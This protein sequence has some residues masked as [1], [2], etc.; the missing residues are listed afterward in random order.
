MDLWL[1]CES[2]GD[3]DLYYVDEDFPN[4]CKVCC[5]VDCLEIHDKIKYPPL[6]VVKSVKKEKK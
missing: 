2:C 6:R 5:S 3:I 1:Q 4:Y